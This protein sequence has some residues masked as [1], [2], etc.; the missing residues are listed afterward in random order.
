MRLDKIPI[1]EV[2]ESFQGEGRFMGQR[3]L[4]IRFAGCNLVGKC[5]YC[6]TDFRV[7]R[8]MS[9]DDIVVEV[10]RYLASNGELVVF[11]GGEPMLYQNVI[12]EIIERSDKSGRALFQVETNGTVEPEM[13][14]VSWIDRIVVSPK[15]G[16]EKRAYEN[17]ANNGVLLRR[18]TD[19]KYVV[20]DV[21]EDSA[22]WSYDRIR[23]EVR[24]LVEKYGVSQR[25]VWLMPY[26]ATKGEL[27]ENA[28]RVWELA[29]ELG[30]NYSDRLHIR[31]WGKSKMGV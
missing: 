9:V 2:F 15:R 30:V 10:M 22:F 12:A 24:W 11:T 5:K 29:K 13:E 6:D 8:M 7:R 27:D 31:V 4:F 26:G 23:S 3:A 19:W 25:D 21:P 1:V 18:I 20:G 14:Y 28:Q 16:Y 17:F